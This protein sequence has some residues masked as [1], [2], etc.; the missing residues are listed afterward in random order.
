MKINSKGY[1]EPEVGEIFKLPN[2]NKKVK[3]ELFEDI[4]DCL[5]CTFYKCDECLMPCSLDERE[6]DSQV[7]YKEIKD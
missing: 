6:D 5:K 7:I 2:S 4:N 1:I 3:V